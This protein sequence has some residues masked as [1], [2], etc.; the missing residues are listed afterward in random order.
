[1]DFF[2]AQWI[3]Y[4]PAFPGMAIFPGAVKVHCANP[5]AVICAVD[6]NDARIGAMD[7]VQA[8]LP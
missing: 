8:C 5:G 1:M 4:K 3:L 6:F 2:H 7:F